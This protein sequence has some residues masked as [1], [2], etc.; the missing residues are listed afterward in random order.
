MKKLKAL[1]L[2]ILSLGSIFMS[3][4]TPVSAVKLPTGPQVASLPLTEPSIAEA[5]RLYVGVVDAHSN[6]TNSV[7]VEA[8]RNCMRDYISKVNL[9]SNFFG[10]MEKENQKYISALMLADAIFAERAPGY[11]NH[12]ILMNFVVNV[13]KNVNSVELDVSLLDITV[14]ANY[15]MENI[16]DNVRR[17]LSHCTRSVRIVG[18]EISYSF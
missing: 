7:T 1:S 6:I 15:H 8:R 14:T 3:N 2:A 18:N 5:R 11:S 9:F 4:Y 12:L 10:T 16:P 13:L 17:I